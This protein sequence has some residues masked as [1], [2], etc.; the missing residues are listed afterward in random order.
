MTITF[1]IHD[2]ASLSGNREQSITISGLTC[3][4]SEMPIVQALT[5]IV[6]KEIASLI[7]KGKGA[8]DGK[9]AGTQTR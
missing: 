8:K 7:N 6:V 1:D 5:D 2:V 9:Q 3:P 4:A